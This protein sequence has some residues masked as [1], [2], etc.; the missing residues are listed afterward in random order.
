MPVEVPGEGTKIEASPSAAEALAPPEFAVEAPPPPKPAVEAPLSPDSAVEV[1]P[2]PEPVAAEAE[3]AQVPANDVVA[4][5]LVQ[6]IVIGAES[7]PPVERKRGW[8]RR[9]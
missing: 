1:L 4:G 6:P 9:L 5:P 7:T 8:W 2:S 3:P